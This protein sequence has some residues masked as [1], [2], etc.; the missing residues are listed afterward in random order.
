MTLQDVLAVF[1]PGRGLPTL[2]GDLSQTEAGRVDLAA[3]QGGAR[4]GRRGMRARLSA[5]GLA[6]RPNPATFDTR[7]ELGGNW[8]IES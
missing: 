5:T 8:T 2:T 1:A 4:F 7:T 3:K 6:E